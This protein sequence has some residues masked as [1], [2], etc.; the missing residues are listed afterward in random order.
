MNHAMV[1]RHNHAKNAQSHYGYVI[2][3]RFI[4]CVHK[5]CNCRHRIVNVCVCVKVCRSQCR[6]F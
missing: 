1:N 4:V 6:M 3:H 2:R 5:Q